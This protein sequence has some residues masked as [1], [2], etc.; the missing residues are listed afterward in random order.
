MEKEEAI[1]TI[2][3]N[4]PEIILKQSEINNKLGMRD[5]VIANQVIKNRNLIVELFKQDDKI[6]DS[7]KL[8]ES[9]LDQ[10][11]KVGIIIKENFKETDRRLKV[12]ESK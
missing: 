6:I 9:Y 3:Q 5:E 11:F 10:L 12:I 4:L 2:V 1:K 8:I 7:L